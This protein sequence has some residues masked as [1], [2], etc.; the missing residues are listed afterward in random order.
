MNWIWFIY[1]DYKSYSSRIRNWFKPIHVL[2]FWVT[3][4]IGIE[5][6]FTRKMNNTIQNHT[7]IIQQRWTPSIQHQS[8]PRCFTKVVAAVRTNG[9]AAARRN[10]ATA[11]D[12]LQRRWWRPCS[13]QS[14]H[15][16]GR[17]AS[18]RRAAAQPPILPQLRRGCD[19]IR[20]F[21]PPCNYTGDLE[22][23]RM[24]GE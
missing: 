10:Q 11:K 5:V 22:M 2:F 7:R 21:V 13:V 15:C 24:Y 17:F 3:F 4:G 12:G 8:I 6:L 19:Q 14:S 23:L 9:V 16:H 1:L 18:C 20:V